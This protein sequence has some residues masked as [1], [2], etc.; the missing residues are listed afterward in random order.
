MAAHFTAK[1]EALRLHRK[2]FEDALNRVERV[3]RSSLNKENEPRRDSTQILSS[4]SAPSWTLAQAQGNSLK[5]GDGR[6][7]SA[8]N[9]A[10]SKGN[11]QAPGP[12]PDSRKNDRRNEQADDKATDQ[13]GNT[14]N[15][16]RKAAAGRGGASKAPPNNDLKAI[17]SLPDPDKERSHETLIAARHAL[18]QQS[19][20]RIQSWL[21]ASEAITMDAE[22][23][24]AIH[25]ELGD[26]SGEETSET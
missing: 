8:T 1:M 2:A 6:D 4:P 18:W 3:A 25:R 19:Y 26:L 12:R 14:L 17:M 20:L 15:A 23:N 7:T 22:H 9:A 10:N 11:S 13:G 24:R 21:R 5:L 16:Q